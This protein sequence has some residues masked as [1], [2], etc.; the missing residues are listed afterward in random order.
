MIVMVDLYSSAVAGDGGGGG[1]LAVLMVTLQCHLT[2]IIL[3]R[4]FFASIPCSHRRQTSQTRSFLTHPSLSTSC[5]RVYIDSL[6]SHRAAR[7]TAARA[8]NVT[9]Y[10]RWREDCQC[11][12]ARGGGVRVK[13]RKYSD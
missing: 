10:V 8:E 9:E 2:P 12:I 11:G 6:L 7:V 4:W 13:E 1:L 3:Q 5:F